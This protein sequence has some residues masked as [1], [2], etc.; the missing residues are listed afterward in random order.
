M[1]RRGAV[2]VDATDSAT[3]KP[4]QYEYPSDPP[5]RVRRWLGILVAVGAVIVL[6][7]WMIGTPGGIEGK[8]DAVGYAIC[9]RIAARSFLINGMPM[10]LCARWTG[11]YLGVMTS[12]LVAVAAGRTKIRLIPPIKVIVVLAT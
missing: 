3:I 7:L 1:Q 10:P 9:H 5:R 11:I 4:V 2:H 8:A 6:V 12:F